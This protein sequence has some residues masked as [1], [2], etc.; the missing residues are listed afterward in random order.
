MIETE[1]SNGTS[2]PGYNLV[3]LFAPGFHFLDYTGLP[4][5]FQQ[6]I[7]RGF[8]R[9]TQVGYKLTVSLDV[10]GSLTKAGNEIQNVDLFHK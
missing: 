6:L 2:L 3:C 5:F 4:E 9:R 10:V 1:H 7:H 8:I